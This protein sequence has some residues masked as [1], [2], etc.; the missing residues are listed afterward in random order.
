MKEEGVSR[1]PPSSSEITSQPR[2]TTPWAYT[3]LHKK[4]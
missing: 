1:L 2:Q 4:K 3:A